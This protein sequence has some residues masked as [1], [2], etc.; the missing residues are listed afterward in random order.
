MAV[1]IKNILA[2]WNTK[3]GHINETEITDEERRIA[4]SVL[5]ILESS[6]EGYIEVDEYLEVDDGEY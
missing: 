1:N 2:I 3:F 4:E 6:R 5:D